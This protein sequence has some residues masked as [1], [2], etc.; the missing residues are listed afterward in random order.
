MV[1]ISQPNA[2][3][4]W[5]SWKTQVWTAKNR[6]KDSGTEIESLFLGDQGA[7]N[8]RSEMSEKNLFGN[9]GWTSYFSDIRNDLIFVLDDGWDVPYGVHP[10]KH[11]DL[12]GSLIASEARFSFLHGSEKEKLKQLSDRIKSCGW[13]GMGIWVAAQM[14]G[15]QY[16]KPFDQK[17]QEIYWTERLLWCKY[18]GVSYWKVDWGWCDNIPEFRAMLT[19]LARKIYPELIVEHAVV[20]QP[21]NGFYKGILTNDGRFIDN[22]DVVSLTDKMLQVSPVFRSYDVTDSLSVA[23]TLDRVFYLLKNATGLINVE[24]EP[25]IGASLG[26]LNGI[27]RSA[28]GKNY[29][30]AA[31]RLLET[32]AAIKW[33]RIAPV[34]SGGTTL[35]SEELLTDYHDFKNG[36]TWFA[37]AI[38]KRIRQSAPAVIARNT[39]LPTVKGKSGAYITCCSFSNGAYA[40][41]A[42]ECSNNKTRQSL[43]VV[44]CEETGSPQIIGVFGRF[45]R[46]EINTSRKIEK[47]IAKGLT[48]SRIVDSDIFEK[49]KIVIDDAFIER[50]KSDDDSAPAFTLSVTYQ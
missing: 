23:T 42:H 48:S 25:Y 31:S 45:G 12:F 8:A 30:P 13:K 41:A 16:G 40:I 3:S 7:R 28:V 2:F 5:C 17:V 35:C 37:P 27:M 24:D 6:I 20:Q 50:F 46:L 22:K 33:Q 11:R 47:I 39:A 19:E 18:A 14:P 32:V 43:P 34:F 1:K 26:C 4:Y 21:L 15:E 49:G 29:T 38:G 9:E 10:D 36:E 44:L